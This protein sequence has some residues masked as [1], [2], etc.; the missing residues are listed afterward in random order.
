MERVETRYLK[1]TLFGVGISIYIF[2]RILSMTEFKD[3]TPLFYF[4]SFGCFSFIAFR[5]FDSANN[6]YLQPLKVRQ[7]DDT[8]VPVILDRSKL[9]THAC[10]YKVCYSISEKEFESIQHD[11]VTTYSGDTK[12]KHLSTKY[13]LYP[14]P[15]LGENCQLADTNSLK[16]K[17]VKGIKDKHPSYEIVNIKHFAY[18][19]K[20]VP[21]Y[22]SRRY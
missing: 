14:L 15:W 20:Q 17:V 6:G 3:I 1:R 21:T 2:S 19:G 10:I 13:E 18:T 7:W 9:K 22:L 16:N 8:V 11:N 5:F 12:K 4:I